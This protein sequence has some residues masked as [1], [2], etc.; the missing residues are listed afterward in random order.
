MRQP[1]AFSQHQ[2]DASPVRGRLD[3]EAKRSFL[4]MVSHELR[5]PLNSIIGFAEILRQELCGPLGSPQYQEY[6]AFISGSGHKMLTLVNQIMEIVRLES[7]ADVMDLQP[8]RLDSALDDA[9]ETL[10]D[11]AEAWGVG[12]EVENPAAM[13]PV[14]ADHRALQTVLVNLLQNALAHSPAGASVRVRAHRLE[15]EVRIEIQDIGPGVDPQ[16]IPRLMLPFE[17]GEQTLTRHLDGAGLGLP[18]VRMLCESMGGDFAL[19][20][21]KGAGVTATVTLLAA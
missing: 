16:D 6:A 12:L 11:E 5:T 13:P 1:S 20:S 15:G 10:K 18:I 8:E 17:Q 7:Q 21:V 14:L 9:M 2:P 4:R 19:D 3:E